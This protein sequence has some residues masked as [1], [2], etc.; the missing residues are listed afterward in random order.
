MNKS[1]MMTLLGLGYTTSDSQFYQRGK[2]EKISFHFHF[3]KVKARARIA[4]M[5]EDENIID[6]GSATPPRVVEAD[7]GA[8]AK[9]S[10]CKKR[11]GRKS[12][13]L[14][15]LCVVID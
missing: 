5:D 2:N 10:V 11:L 6:S 1:L 12:K 7:D 14:L 15:I 13:L 9:C 4:T 8:T 3:Q